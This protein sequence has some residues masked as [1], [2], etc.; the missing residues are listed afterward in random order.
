MSKLRVA[1]VRGGPSD[2][3]DVSLSSAQSV[4]EHLD[5]T[6]YEVIDVFVS[7]EGK[8]SIDGAGATNDDQAIEDLNHMCIDVVFLAVHGTY[9][10]DGVL[11]KKL[12]LAGLKF[13][14]SGWRASQLAFDKIEAD[15]VYRQNDL[16]VP[17]TQ[18]I[19]SIDDE[20]VIEIPAVVKP[21]SQG[22]SVGVTIVKNSNSLPDAVKKAFEYDD[23]VVVQELIV[24]REVSCGVIETRHGLT[25]LPPTE[26]I[27]RSAEFYD[28]DAKYIAGASEEITP[29]NMPEETILKIQQLSKQ[30]HEALGCKGY[31]RTDMFV[32]SGDEIYIIETNTLPGMTPT[33]I[34]PQQAAAAGISFSSLLDQIIDNA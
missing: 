12:E 4:K 15:R 10:E 13:T 8:W 9:G 26:I 17:K 33:S 34:L 29:P 7:K 5:M 2:E 21:A 22:S 25:A 28:Y 24:G 11:Q 3:H 19:D 14:G 1:I 32:T 30:A 6:K 16:L 18:A 27:P 23:H 20:I 31:S